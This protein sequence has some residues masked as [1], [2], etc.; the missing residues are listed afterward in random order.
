MSMYLGKNKKDKYLLRTVE[1][2]RLYEMSWDLR[3][4]LRERKRE[5]ENARAHK[6]ERE[7]DVNSSLKI[8][9]KKEN[10][11]KT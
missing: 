4:R 8:I 10:E 7:R 6:R 11:Q 2:H 5:R 3:E 1:K 9:N